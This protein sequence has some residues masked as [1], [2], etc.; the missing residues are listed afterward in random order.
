MIFEE[1]NSDDEDDDG[2]E[3][4]ETYSNKPTIVKLRKLVLKIRRS[5]QKR[6]VAKTL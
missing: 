3:I 2:D 1:Q 5:P 4:D 6:Q